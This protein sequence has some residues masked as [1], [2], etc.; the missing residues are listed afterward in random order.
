M[1]N[2]TCGGS[3][4]VCPLRE[5]TPPLG[6]HRVR[7]QRSAFRAAIRRD[8]HA[9]LVAKEPFPKGRMR[10][11]NPELRAHLGIGD[12]AILHSRLA[13]RAIHFLLPLTNYVPFAAGRGQA[14]LEGCLVP[15]GDSRGGLCQ[16][17]PLQARMPMLA[18]NDVVVQ[19]CLHSS[20]P[21]KVFAIRFA[22][23]RNC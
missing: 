11:G 1:P 8:G 21:R 7:F 2:L 20:A 4:T 17:Q 3:A 19:S 14:S 9:I 6:L 22:N 13:F 12:E 18:D 5:R 10:A 16:L 15:D 23:F